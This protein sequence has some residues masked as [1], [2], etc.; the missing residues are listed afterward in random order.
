M[1]ATRPHHG[2]SRSRW[3]WVV[4]LLFG[5]AGVAG[6]VVRNRWQSL[7]TERFAV[8]S[9]EQLTRR[10]REGVATGRAP[11]GNGVV[12]VQHRPGGDD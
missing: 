11:I 5:I 2:R 6:A 1:D 4:T 8:R 3:P 9:A 10:Y 12:R 7:K